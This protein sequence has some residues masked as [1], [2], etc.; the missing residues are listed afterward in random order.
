MTRA[1]VRPETKEGFLQWVNSFKV[2]DECIAAWNDLEQDKNRYAIFTFTDDGQGLVVESLAP[3][4]ATY[5]N[6]LDEL[7][8]RDVRYAVYNFEYEEAYSTRKKLV[9]VVWAPTV[10]P[11]ARKLLRSMSELP[12]S[13]A[14]RTGRAGLRLMATC[15]DELLERSVDE[16]CRSTDM[17]S[18]YIARP[19][20]GFTSVYSRE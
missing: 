12:V 17:D 7:P 13:W 1:D 15:W 11:N 3:M 2:H 5:D 4:E 10:A 8:P 6:F 14:L 20:G 19:Y 16:G 18:F 9:F